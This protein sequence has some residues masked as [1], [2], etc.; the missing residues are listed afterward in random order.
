MGKQENRVHLL[1]SISI[2]LLSLV[3]FLLIFAIFIK[4]DDYEKK[5]F[6]ID[7]NYE[8]NNNIEL[9]TKLP[10]SDSIAKNYTGKGIEKGIAEY[11][12]FTISNPNSK[13]IEYEIF[14]TKSVN[15]VEDIRS[16]YIKLYLTD[17]NDNPVKGF[18]S[19]IVKSYYDLYSLSD[20]PGSKLLYTGSLLPGETDSFILRSWLADSYIITQKVEDFNYSIDVRIK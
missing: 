10:I 17:G 7:I 20:M 4:I 11:K 9:V 5:S 15:G 6:K 14:L 19:N 18:E 8:T 1:K 2:V 13:K 16:N 3:A 12:P